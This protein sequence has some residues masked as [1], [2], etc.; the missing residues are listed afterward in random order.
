[1]N[2]RQHS[3]LVNLNRALIFALTLMGL[4]MDGMQLSDLPVSVALLVWLWL[5]LCTRI[6]ASLVRRLSS[7]GGH[8]GS[9]KLSPFV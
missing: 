3:F 4:L 8:A 6:E 1:M 7:E 2:T 9:A 5:P